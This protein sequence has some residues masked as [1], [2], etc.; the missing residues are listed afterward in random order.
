MCSREQ[1]NQIIGRFG[2][3]RIGVVGDVVADRYITGITDRVS[4]EAPIIIVRQEREEVIPGGSANVARNIA[5]LGAKVELVALIGDDDLGR[6]VTRACKESG[7]GVGGVMVSEGCPTVTKTRVLAGATHTAPQQVLRIDHEPDG[8]VSARGQRRLLNRI[9]AIDR[10][11][12]AWMISDYGYHLIGASLREWFQSA[13]KSKPVLADS[14]YAILDY[15]NVTAI[16]PN[17]RE[18][19]EAA[20]VAD[21]REQGLLEAARRLKQRTRAQAVIITL[22]NKGMLVYRGRSNFRFVRA[23]GTDEIVDLTGAGDTAGAAL[24]TALAAGSDFY[25]AAVLA[26]CAASVVVMKQGCACCTRNELTSVVGEYVSD[27]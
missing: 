19:L 6:E 3:S 25:S 7:V 5:A 8:H 10:R 22:G 9:E 14:R 12:G 13:A 26:T 16:K 17:E 11:V 24:I 27:E 15:R 4:R 2:H 21:H 23:V 1:L 20:G 18:A